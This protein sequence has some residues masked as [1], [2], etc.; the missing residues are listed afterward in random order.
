MLF[1]SVCLF[2]CFILL[3][4]FTVFRIL[5]NSTYVTPIVSILWRKQP[6]DFTF[7]YTCKYPALYMW[8]YTVHIYLPM[9]ISSLPSNCEIETVFC[10]F[11]GFIYFAH[12]FC[13]RRI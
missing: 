11:L 8:I 6:G 7:S 5:L 10:F 9:G 2:V 13:V 12:T 1:Y 4:I 3:F